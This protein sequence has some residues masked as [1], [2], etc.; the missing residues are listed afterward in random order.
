L[1]RADPERT[2]EPG[3]WS[4]HASTL[5]TGGTNGDQCVR[6]DKIDE[7]L[8]GPHNHHYK[9]AYPVRVVKDGEA[10]FE[11]ECVSKHDNRYRISLQGHYAP[12]SFDLHGRVEGRLLGVPL[13]VPVSIQARRIGA[14]CPAPDPH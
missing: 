9:C 14:D 1:A 5:I 12:Q 11:G 13:S 8:S 3:Y 2:I 4:Y 10:R 7:F 6:P